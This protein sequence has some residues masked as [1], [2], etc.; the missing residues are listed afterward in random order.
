[1]KIRSN[2]VCL[3]RGAVCPSLLYM[4]QSSRTDCCNSL[5]NGLSAPAI[6]TPQQ[7]QNGCARFMMIRLKRDH[8]FGTQTN[9]SV[10]N[11][12]VRRQGLG[13][14]RLWWTSQ[15]VCGENKGLP[16]VSTQ[17]NCWGVSER[18]WALHSCELNPFVQVY[19]SYILHVL[20]AWY[21]CYA[22]LLCW[23]LS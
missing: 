2:R 1:M 17:P 7:V 12:W 9:I 16:G 4:P 5:L 11:P 3:K 22:K 15:E 20:V 10:D 13:A 19:D 14:H 21:S 6:E 8:A 18:H 23:Q